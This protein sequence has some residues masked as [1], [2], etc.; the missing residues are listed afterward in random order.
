MG[1]LWKRYIAMREEIY[2]CNTCDCHLS[3]K[4]Q[5]IS[6]SFHGRGGRAFLMEEVI[7]V[8]LGPNETR[9]LVTGMHVVADIN[10]IDCH[11]LL[12]WKYKEAHEETQ[13]YKEGHYILEESRI[14]FKP[15]V[16]ATATVPEAQL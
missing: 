16:A 10:C 6:K 15:V 3:S 4:S 8:Y 9:M 5:I 11:T 12:G 14:T 1:R 2:T 7:N 13:K